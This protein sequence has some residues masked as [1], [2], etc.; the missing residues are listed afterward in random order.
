MY[1]NP[2]WEYRLSKALFS[3]LLFF[4]HQDIVHWDTFEEAIFFFHMLTIIHI[5]SLFQM[6]LKNAGEHHK[7]KWKEWLMLPETSHASG[8]LGKPTHSLWK[9]V[10][11]TSLLEK[12]LWLMSSD[13][14]GSEGQ[15]APAFLPEP[16][17]CRQA[18]ICKVLPSTAFLF[19][20]RELSFLSTVFYLR[21][22][23]WKGFKGTKQPFAVQPWF[24]ELAGL[25]SFRRTWQKHLKSD[26]RMDSFEVLGA[27]R[28]LRT[29][30][31]VLT[32]TGSE[33]SGLIKSCTIW[34]FRDLFWKV[35]RYKNCVSSYKKYSLINLLGT[36]YLFF[37]NRQ[38]HSHTLIK[39]M[40]Q[41]SH[42]TLF[43]LE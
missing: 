40:Y 42:D 2:F 43:S 31:S 39:K 34:H 14:W 41:V 9:G 5:H 24:N 17:L 3:V 20:H 28:N 15:V 18:S 10:A 22:H 37:L 6:S 21:I 23:I 30:K 12:E 7:H 19:H 35:L 8:K 11:P 33:V 29:M 36:I 4:V 26:F 27:K 38:T 32:A 25:V 1:Q 13:G 16:E